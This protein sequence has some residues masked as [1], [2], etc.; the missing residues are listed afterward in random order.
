[1]SE[2]RTRHDIPA[3][4]RMIADGH[5]VADELATSRQPLE[6]VNIAFE[7]AAARRGIRAMIEFRAGGRVGQA[8]TAKAS[9]TS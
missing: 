8:P 7:H 4:M 5:L 9:S 3:Y 1:M 6:E 2:V